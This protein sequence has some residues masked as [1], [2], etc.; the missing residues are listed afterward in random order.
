MSNDYTASLHSMAFWSSSDIQHVFFRVMNRRFNPGGVTVLMLYNYSYISCRER[1]GINES[2][3]IVRRPSLEGNRYRNGQAFFIGL[4]TF[5]STSALHARFRCRSYCPA[6][7][8][9]NQPFNPSV[10]TFHL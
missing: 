2:N 7:G 6:L 5:P 1:S 9:F 8:L 10:Q 3:S 4:S